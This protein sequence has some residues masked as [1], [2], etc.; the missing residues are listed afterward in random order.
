MNLQLAWLFD[1]DGTLLVTDGAPRE[2]FARA[3]R[4]SIGVEDDLS[5]IEF[6]G[7]VEPRILA[8][9]LRKHRVIL[10]HADEAR[11]WNQVFDHMQVAM[12]PGRGR[13]LPGVS[14]LLDAVDR[15]PEWA[16]GLLTGN[17]TQMA[18]I[19]LGHFGIA[20]R[21]RF[22]AFGEEA[23][24]RNALAVEAVRRVNERFGI[25]A[26][27]CIVVGD[28]EHDVTCARVA[29]ARVVA[30]A[31]GRT[32]RDTLEAL[33]PDLTLD[34]LTDTRRVLDWAHAITSAPTS[35]RAASNPPITGPTT[36]GRK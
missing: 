13:L 3:L 31:T 16:A 14:E 35:S 6:A 25:P 12:H 33:E 8:D 10:E 17:M 24:D 4:D 1:I 18:R 19:K 20:K 2:C 32:K 36:V 5:D 28:T 15:E 27:R 11:F 9:I 7:R 34:D 29:G 30:V 22:G 26:E 23:T 21:F